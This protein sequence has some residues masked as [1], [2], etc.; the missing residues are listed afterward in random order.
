M[1]VTVLMP[2]GHKSMD[3]SLHHEKLIITPFY[4]VYPKA[5]A[6]KTNSILW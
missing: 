1:L 2:N 6:S 5:S 3:T 4:T